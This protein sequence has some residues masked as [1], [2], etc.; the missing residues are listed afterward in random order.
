MLRETPGLKYALE[1]PMLSRVYYP[2]CRR[3]LFGLVRDFLSLNENL[4]IITAVE[5][6]V[7]IDAR[8]VVGRLI[9]RIVGC[10]DGM[11]DGLLNGS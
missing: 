2:D 6:N 4:C 11:Y 8:N 9:G 5:F 3:L 10:D 7:R 1:L